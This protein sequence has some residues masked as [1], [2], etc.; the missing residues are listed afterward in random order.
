[1]CECVEKKSPLKDFRVMLKKDQN[2][3]YYFRIFVRLTFAIKV[4]CYSFI[5]YN[6]VMSLFVITCCH[7]VKFIGLTIRKQESCAL[8]FQIC[9]FCVWILI[10]IAIFPNYVALQGEN[11][12]IG[13]ISQEKL[14]KIC[15]CLVFFP[16]EKVTLLDFW[17]NKI[18][19]KGILCIK[20][21]LALLTPAL[22]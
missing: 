16:Q 10:C 14:S 13:K 11:T 7:L 4:A 12:G 1:M 8:G 18:K 2:S 19:F 6:L 21:V 3:F 17:R 22:F 20:H 5:I 15:M 9:A